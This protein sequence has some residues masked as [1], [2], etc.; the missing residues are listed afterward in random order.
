MLSKIRMYVFIGHNEH[1]T[2]DNCYNAVHEMPWTEILYVGLC[3]P[4]LLSSI[5]PH[6]QVISTRDKQIFQ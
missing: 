4:I 3:T 6:S 5:S 2:G 1:K